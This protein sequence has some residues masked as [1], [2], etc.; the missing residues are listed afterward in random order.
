MAI[1]QTVT[2]TVDGKTITLPPGIYPFGDLVLMANAPKTTKS[3]AVNSTVSKAS[4]IGGNDSYD[5]A[6]GEVFTTS[7]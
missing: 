1:K 4:T 3:I 6:G 2:I 5:I 7:H